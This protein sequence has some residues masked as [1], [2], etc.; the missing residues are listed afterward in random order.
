MMKRLVA[1]V[2]SSIFAAGVN[3]ADF[4]SGLGDGN[5]DLSAQRLSAEDFSGVQPSVGDSVARYHG[6]ASGN[7]DLFKA[8]RSG[9]TDSGNDPNIYRGLSG[10]PDLQFWGP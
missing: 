7:P 1:V 4:Y 3:A 8:R 5:S 2:A 10:N 6:W 9:Q